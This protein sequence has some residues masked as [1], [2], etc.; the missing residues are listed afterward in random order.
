M[1]EL[2]EVESVVRAHRDKLIGR[3]IAAFESLWPRQVSPDVASLREGVCGRRIEAVSRR[4]KFIV[5]SLDGGA[6][7]LVHL[8]MSGRFEWEEN[9]AEASHVRAIFSL[10]DGRRLLFCD[11]RKFGR[12]IYT[13][14][15]SATTARLG[16]E[17][18]S[19]AFTPECLSDVL[20]R[21]ARRIKPLLLDQ[22]QIAGLGNIYTDE[23]LFRAGIHPLRRSDSLSDAEL[24]RL[25][26]AIRAVL[27]EGIRRN[28]ASID[29]VYPGGSMQEAFRVYGRAGEACDA[30]GERIVSIRVGQRGTHLCPRCQPRQ[31]RRTPRG[32]LSTR[33]R[34]R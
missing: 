6:F 20:R 3:R 17:L 1:P 14:D 10:D 21:R 7:V 15:L 9:G 29:W 18:L 30:C 27:R 33:R 34:R 12:I 26:A 11:A 31:P 24:A 25:R 13:R 8:R 16:V 22:T 5:L 32:R 4:G 2:P 28:G 23:S 19:R